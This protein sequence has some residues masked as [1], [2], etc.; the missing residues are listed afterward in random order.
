MDRT[1]PQP[2]TVTDREPLCDEQGPI[3]QFPPRRAFDE[4][5][6]FIPLTPE[7]REARDDAFRR[8]MRRIDA[9]DQD[10]PGSNED[11][12]RAIDSRRPEGSKLFEGSY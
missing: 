10:P 6:R 9:T 11:F 2:E 8:T 12:L 7:E 1:E 3:P 4:H 5:G